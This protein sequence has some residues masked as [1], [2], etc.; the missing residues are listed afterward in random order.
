[1]ICGV[2]CGL[3]FGFGTIEGVVLGA[4]FNPE[5]GIGDALMFM[6]DWLNLFYGFFN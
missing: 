5:D 2:D 3:A 6:L 1:L 4:V